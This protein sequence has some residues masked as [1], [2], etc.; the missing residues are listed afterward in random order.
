MFENVGDE[1]DEDG[2]SESQSVKSSVISVTC[3]EPSANRQVARS[4]SVAH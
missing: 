2:E 3:E 4:N 1:E